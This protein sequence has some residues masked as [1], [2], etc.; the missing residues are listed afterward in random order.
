MKPPG[1]VEHAAEQVGTR[2][3]TLGHPFEKMQA[4]TAAETTSGRP[5]VPPDPWQSA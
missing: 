4:S 1:L 3:S 2:F 5:G